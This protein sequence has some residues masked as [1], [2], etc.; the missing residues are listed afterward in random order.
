MVLVVGNGTAMDSSRNRRIYYDC[1]V[2]INGTIKKVIKTR[3]IVTSLKDIDEK[4]IFMHVLNLDQQLDGQEIWRISPFNAGETRPSFSLYCKGG[5]RYKWKDF[6][7]GRSGDAFELAQQLNPEKKRGELIRELILAYQQYLDGNPPEVEHKIYNKY[8]VSSFQL[9]T[10]NSSDAKYWRQYHIGS[11]TLDFFNIAPLDSFV[12]SKEVDGRMDHKRISREL[13]YGYFRKTGELFKIYQPG[14]EVKFIKVRSGYLQ[15]FDQLKFDRPNLLITKSLKDCAGFHTLNI[16]GFE[17]ISSDSE[18]QMITK[19]QM[20]TLN[21]Y[22]KRVVLFDADPAG[23]QAAKKYK[24][25]YGLPHID[26]ELSKDITD[27]MKD[28]GAERVREKLI[29]LLKKF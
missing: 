10:W 1:G 19:A 18:N 9:R 5:P 11:K 14:N 20:N 8:K 6:S 25:T 23:I 17:V 27:S 4:F 22:K 12:M 13:I 3:N 26:L 16:P 29:T 24:E 2:C 15:G 21:F 28:F 7:S